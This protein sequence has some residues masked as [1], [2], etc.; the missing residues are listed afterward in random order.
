MARFGFMLDCRELDA[1]GDASYAFN[2]ERAARRAPPMARDEWERQRHA[3]YL[4]ELASED[5]VPLDEYKAAAGRAV[6][7]DG[8]ADAAELAP[9]MDAQTDGVSSTS[10]A[11]A[12]EAS[13]SAGYSFAFDPMPDPRNTMLPNGRNAWHRDLAIYYV[14]SGVK[15]MPLRSDTATPIV[16]RCYDDERLIKTESEASAHWSENKTD[17]IGIPAG[18][19]NLAIIDSDH[20]DGTK[21]GLKELDSY[22][23]KH[24][25]LPDTPATITGTGGRHIFFKSVDG[26]KFKNSVGKFLPANDVRA[27]NGYVVAQGVVKPN[28]KRNTVAPGTIPFAEAFALGLI[29]DMPQWLIDDL[30]KH[31]DDYQ[32]TDYQD[33]DHDDAGHEDGQQA[34]PATDGVRPSSKKPTQREI[35]HAKGVL[36]GIIKDYEALGNGSHRNAALNN[37][38]LRLGHHVKSG[39]LTYQD[40]YDTLYAA[41]RRNGYLAKDGHVAVNNT[42]RSGI[43]AGMREDARPP[44]D[45]PRDGATNGQRAERERPLGNSNESGDDMRLQHKTAQPNTARHWLNLHNL[46]QSKGV[47]LRRAGAELMFAGYTVIGIGKGFIEFAAPMTPDDCIDHLASALPGL[48]TPAIV[49]AF[50][51]GEYDD[52]R[53]DGAEYKE[54]EQEPT[55]LKLDVVNAASLAGV[56]F[57]PREWLVENVIPH[58]TVT[59]FAGD[60]GV[61]KSLLAMQLAVAVAT[62]GCWI[63][64]KPSLGTVVYL[65]AEDEVRDIHGRLLD[66]I[67]DLNSL[68]NLDIVPLADLDATLAVPNKE[69]LMEPTAMFGAVEDVVIDKRPDLLVLDTQADF[70]GG[71]EI[72][73]IQARGFIALLRRLAIQYNMTVLLLSHPSQSGMASGTGTSGNVAWN[74]SVRSR[75][76]L[77]RRFIR[78]GNRIIEEDG[79]ARILSVKKAN[80][81]KGGDQIVL[82]WERGVFVREREDERDEGDIKKR[83]ERVFMTLLLKYIRQK[84]AVSDKSGKNYA[85]SVFAGDDA[86]EGITRQQF[87][88]A[89]N[90]LFDDEKIRVDVI[91]P[92]SRQSRNVVPNNSEHEDRQFD[93]DEGMSVDNEDGVPWRRPK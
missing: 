15:I 5:V 9:A 89:M 35:N 28:G 16:K 62:N 14:R 26:I 36:R 69:G 11:P 79:D 47:S 60:G 83:A 1:Y 7:P 73:K 10:E 42:I 71:D 17:L 2:A 61:G 63:G 41:T 29:A 21:P 44:K 34:P 43:N 72:K 49:D 75:L 54:A 55:R 12:E 3:E 52:G 51:R 66:M 58:G 67:G 27:C 56:R 13:G 31:G 82:R 33:A 6:W 46:A 90:R 23:A 86:N 68:H 20:K 22:V 53:R 65:S 38:A 37:A 93:D 48:F 30:P 92:P 4:A 64:L 19:N 76:Y 77:E 45:R 32:D 40:V 24:G 57:Q 18:A 74:N 39:H 85:P 78:D 81:A 80:Y 59:L 84:R 87:A 25:K 8:D 91:G 50:R 88:S 70:F